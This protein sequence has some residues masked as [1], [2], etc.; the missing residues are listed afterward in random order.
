MNK[1]TPV[2]IKDIALVLNISVSTVSRALRG[3]PEIHPDTKNAILKLAEEMD[4]QP[5]QLAK[6][7]VGNRTKTIGVIMPTLSYYFFSSMLNSIEEAAMQA[8]Y[9]VIVCQTNESYLREK[10]QIQN[11]L[12]S[13]VEG[14]IISLACDSYDYEHINRLIRKQIPL[15]LFD[16]YT[17]KLE[18]SKV[19]V[20]N[21]Q[22]AFKATS[23]LIENGCKKLSCLAGPP[24]LEI[25]NQRLEG[26]KEALSS[27]GLLYDERYVSHSD[28]TQENTIIQA[29][30]MMSLAVP[31]D[32][33]LTMSDRIA[34]STMY[35]LKQKGIK[36]P[37]DVAMVSFNNEPTCMY[38]TP[39]LTSV[40][41]PIREMGTQSVRLLLKQLESDKIE[42][43]TVI[44]DTQLVIR[45]SS[46][47]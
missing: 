32:G 28:F 7:L 46:L 11:M 19:I 47:R 25:S 16:R 44:L 45:E 17:D 24:H 33:I 18:V 29:N 27:H 12:N 4:Y 5:N 3:M 8:G 42:P 9:S 43:E 14:F 41:Q 20:D 2:T 22:A 40:N 13:Q 10:A 21:K 1:N 34:F 35:A 6:N 38:L 30:N 37:E 15:V 26:F 31:P 39:S 23:H 36:I